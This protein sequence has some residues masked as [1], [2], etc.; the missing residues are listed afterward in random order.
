MPRE[1]AAFGTSWGKGAAAGLAS[2]AKPRP[3]A[4]PGFIG[5][6]YHSHV[7][8][9]IGSR[10]F[11]FLFGSVIQIGKYVGGEE[12]D[13]SYIPKIIMTAEHRQAI[14]GGKMLTFGHRQKFGNDPEKHVD[15]S[16]A[17][18]VATG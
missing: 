7:T 1:I 16:A 17:T 10:R 8:W 2:L 5:D 14:Y 12:L 11:K 9:G 3:Q 6:L 13:M 18:L 4:N 15:S